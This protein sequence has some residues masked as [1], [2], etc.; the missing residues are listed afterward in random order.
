MFI[1]Q[2]I[3]IYIHI[4]ISELLNSITTTIRHKQ[5]ANLHRDTQIIGDSVLLHVEQ[6]HLRNQV[7]FVDQ[8]F[9]YA[10]IDNYKGVNMI[11]VQWFEDDDR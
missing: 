11:Y 1:C 2:Y 5:C 7:E 3:Y 4:D 9:T 10:L 6:G 8:R